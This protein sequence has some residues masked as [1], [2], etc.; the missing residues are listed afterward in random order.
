MAK[1]HAYLNFD[2]NC[3][4]AFTFYEKVFQT[5]NPGYMRYGDIPAD[6]QMPAIPDEAKNKIC[7]TAISINGESMLMGADVVPAFGQQYVQGNNTY[8]M[9]MCDNAEEAKTL[10][11]ALSVNAKVVEMP[12]GETFFAELYSSFQDQ[13]GICWMVYFGGSKDEDCESKS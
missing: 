13:F 4:E 6:P 10:H 2:G 11:T 1:L 8:V 3:E 7:H 12:L 5:K 9:L